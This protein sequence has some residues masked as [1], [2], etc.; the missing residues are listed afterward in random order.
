MLQ[1]FVKFCELGRV[2]W[3]GTESSGGLLWTRQWNFNSW[4]AERLSTSEEGI[5]SVKFVS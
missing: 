4:L 1:K 5:W 2:L 3:L